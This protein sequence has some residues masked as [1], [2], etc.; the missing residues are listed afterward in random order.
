MT[1]PLPYAFLVSV[2]V[3][4]VSVEGVSVSTFVIGDMI[5]MLVVCVLRQRFLD[6]LD[7]TSLSLWRLWR[8]YSSYVSFLYAME[9]PTKESMFIFV[10]P[11]ASF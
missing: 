3:G 4:N 7:M 11:R 8:S 6:F 5:W 2:D 1:R 9:T 10:L